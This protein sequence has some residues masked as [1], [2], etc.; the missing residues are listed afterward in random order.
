MVK[1]V[2]NYIHVVMTLQAFCETTILCSHVCFISNVCCFTFYP[3]MT[4]LI[5]IALCI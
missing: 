3:C 5:L 4:A 2:L 1:W